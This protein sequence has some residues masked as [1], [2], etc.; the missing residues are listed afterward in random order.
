ML[1]R[2]SK[3]E[4]KTA[5]VEARGAWIQIKRH[6]KAKL[7][8]ATVKQKGICNMKRDKYNVKW[9]VCGTLCSPGE[10]IPLLC[11]L[12]S[13]ILFQYST[14]LPSFLISSSPIN[15]V[16]CTT[17]SPCLRPYI[18]SSFQLLAVKITTK[19]LV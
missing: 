15:W 18:L 2:Q 14:Q 5:K 7:V 8:R 9:I 3:K 16:S 10:R 1:L 11:N 4:G 12:S 6:A 13:E 17:L 19:F